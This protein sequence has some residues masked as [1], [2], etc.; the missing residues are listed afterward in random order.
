MAEDLP[1]SPAFKTLCE[2]LLTYETGQQ[3][4]NPATCVST[5]DRLAILN[6]RLG[7]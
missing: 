3:A 1:M 5:T 4:L 6:L 7:H 2:E